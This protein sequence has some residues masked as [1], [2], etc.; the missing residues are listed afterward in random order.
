M[1]FTDALF[2]AQVIFGIV[3]AQKFST[4]IALLHKHTFLKLCVNKTKL[5]WYKL[6]TELLLKNVRFYKYDS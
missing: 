1:M 3:M 5:L 4:K 6:P 2:S